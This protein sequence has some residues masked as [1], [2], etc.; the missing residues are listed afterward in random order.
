MVKDCILV[1]RFG[2]PHGVRGEVRL[3]SF[4][5]VP[6]AIATYKPL[7]DA[8]A[9]RQF[10]IKTL[11]PLKDDMFVARVAGI[12]DRAAAQSLTNLEV[13]VARDNLPKIADEDFYIADLIGLAAMNAAGEPVGRV[14]NVLNFGGGD[15]LEIAPPD[16]GQTLLLP[17]TKEVVP[18]I[19]VKAGCLTVA[20]PVEIEANGPTDAH[21]GVGP[22]E[23]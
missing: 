2:A 12:D 1:G 9:T 19:D 4:T 22:S 15:I 18:S 11:R 3:Q 21:L 8:S 14:V 6:D 20:P 23:N 17:F 16:A 7:F 10:T 5:G 13:F